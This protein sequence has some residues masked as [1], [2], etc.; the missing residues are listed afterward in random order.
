[1]YLASMEDLA[2]H[3]GFLFSWNE[4]IAKGYTIVDFFPSN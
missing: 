4:A 2:T 1:M 3:F